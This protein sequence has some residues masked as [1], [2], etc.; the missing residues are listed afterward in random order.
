MSKKVKDEWKQYLLDEKED[1]SVEQI[2]E[3]FKYAVRQYV[4]TSDL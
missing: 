1:Y 4:M 2:I 3:K